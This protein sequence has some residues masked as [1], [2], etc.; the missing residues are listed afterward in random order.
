MPNSKIWQI[1]SQLLTIWLVLNFLIGTPWKLFKKF[2]SKCMNYMYILLNFQKHPIKNWTHSFLV[3]FFMTHQ[4]PF[5]FS[6]ASDGFWCYINVQFFKA[7]RYNLFFNPHLSHHSFIQF[8][9]PQ[10]KF[11]ENMNMM[12]SSNITIYRWNFS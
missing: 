3:Q 1:K 2:E 6:T 12:S 8:S 4:P 10:S 9:R 5:N 11:C 7:A